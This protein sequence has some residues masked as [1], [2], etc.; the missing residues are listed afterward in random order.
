MKM[1]CFFELNKEKLQKQWDEAGLSSLLYI[2]TVLVLYFILLGLI[3][4]IQTYKV[5]A[6]LF[7]D[8]KLLIRTLFR[9][10]DQFIQMI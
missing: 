4:L 7:Q 1:K 8:D 3:I 2:I 5:E 10:V 9:T 6:K